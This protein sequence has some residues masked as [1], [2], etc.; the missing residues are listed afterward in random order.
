MSRIPK[1]SAL[2][3]K[4]WSA[5]L[6][7]APLGAIAAGGN[8]LTLSPEGDAWPR[9]QARLSV[10]S[11]PIGSSA[12]SGANLQFGAARLAGDRYFDVGR[13]GDGGGLRATSALL[14]GSTRLAMGAPSA[15][16]QAALQWQPSALLSNAGGDGVNELGATPYVGLGYSAWWSRTGLGLSADLGLLAHRGSPSLRLAAGDGADSAQ[17]PFQLQPVFQVNLS[18]SF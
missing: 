2:A 15:Y 14:M 1:L 16:G 6:L 9:W 4:R 7:L 12:L 3:P 11:Q 13:V 8:G 17:R 5:W 18:Y 10:V